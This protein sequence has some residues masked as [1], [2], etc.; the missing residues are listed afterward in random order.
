MSTT[1]PQLPQVVKDFGGYSFYV[2]GRY[3][4]AVTINGV[5]YNARDYKGPVLARA[6]AGEFVV[7]FLCL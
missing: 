2:N 3:P 1:P 4:S 6:G 7:R 5:Q